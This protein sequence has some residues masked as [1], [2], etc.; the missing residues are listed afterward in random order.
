M[1]SLR[2]HPF[3][4]LGGATGLSSKWPSISSRCCR[5]PGVVTA[6]SRCGVVAAAFEAFENRY[7]ETRQAS[8]LTL[9]Q[10]EIVELPLVEV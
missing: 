4:E 6:A 5:H 8:F 1:R 9:M 10:R 3:S 7:L 2:P